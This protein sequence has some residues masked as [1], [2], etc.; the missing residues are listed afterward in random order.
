MLQILQETIVFL[1]TPAHTAQVET[2]QLDETTGRFYRNP[3]L[4]V[5]HPY[6]ATKIMFIPDKESQETD[7]MA[8]S[9]DY[10]AHMADP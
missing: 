3:K 1:H 10:F 8:T 4:S 5:E 6:P 7:L 2:V 9:G